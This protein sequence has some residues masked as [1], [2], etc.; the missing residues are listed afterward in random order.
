MPLKTTQKNLDSYKDGWH[1]LC[2]AT[3]LYPPAQYV[4]QACHQLAEQ[5]EVINIVDIQVHWLRG[6]LSQLRFISVLYT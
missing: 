6:H 4:D 1:T 5:R 3:L 2:D